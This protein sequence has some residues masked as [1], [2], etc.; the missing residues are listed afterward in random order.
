M[1][2]WS[3]NQNQNNIEFNPYS[4]NRTSL[5][6]SNGSLENYARELASEK[7]IDINQLINQLQGGL[8]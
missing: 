5:I 8:Q 4:W 3:Q 2:T 7:G 1:N 6:K